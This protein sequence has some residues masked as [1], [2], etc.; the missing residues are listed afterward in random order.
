MR[1]DDLLKGMDRERYKKT[2]AYLKNKPFPLKEKT[3]TYAPSKDLDYGLQAEMLI[4]SGLCPCAICGHE[5]M[6][7]CEEDNCEC[8]SS[9]CC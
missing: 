8:C 4:V 9:A 7:E 5:F 2:V 3:G 6:W 1:L